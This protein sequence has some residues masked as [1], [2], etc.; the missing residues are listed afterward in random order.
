M[1]LYVKQFALLLCNV[2]L[3]SD[4]YEEKLKEE[5]NG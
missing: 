5:K 4:K 1:S 2:F 3:V